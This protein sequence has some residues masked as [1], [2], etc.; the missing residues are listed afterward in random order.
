MTYLNHL[1]SITWCY[2]D[3]PESQ[4]MQADLHPAAVTA[5]ASDWGFCGSTSIEK[6][7]K[8]QEIQLSW[9][10]KFQQTVGF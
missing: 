9:F 6:V 5:L 10:V 2:I 8:L 1:V 4:E 7:A 3:D